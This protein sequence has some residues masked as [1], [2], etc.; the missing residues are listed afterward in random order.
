[1]AL[2][3]AFGDLACARPGAQEAPAATVSL[4]SP[5]PAGADAPPGPLVPPSLVELLRPYLVSDARVGRRALYT[6]TT[7]EQV[8]ELGRDRVLLTRT[9]SPVHG[10]AYS[11]QVIAARAAGGDRLAALLRTAPFLRARHAWPA[12]FATLLGWPGETYGMELLRVE[13]KPEAWIAK[14]RTSKKDWEVVDLDDHLVD[15]EEA[16]RHP[17]RIAAEYFVHDLP[18]PIR[19]Q[20]TYGSRLVPGRPAFREYVL[21][22]ESMIARWSV[23]TPES[24]REVAAEVEA[25]EALRQHVAALGKVEQPTLDAWNTRVA[26]EVWAALPAAE[27]TPLALY[28]SALAFPNELY[29]PEAARLA[30]LVERLRQ[31]TP[32]GPSLEHRPTLSFNAAVVPPPGAAPPTARPARPAPVPAKRRNGTY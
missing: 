18:Q 10:P 21:C 30:V 16:L 20:G 5:A 32:H 2:T 8:E 11:D 6:W 23:G 3:L 27:S 7:R 24:T 9:E 14:I 1:V 15:T 25:I 28:E 4:S 26:L 17:E 22:N 13:L 19:I 12:P 29:R 31:A